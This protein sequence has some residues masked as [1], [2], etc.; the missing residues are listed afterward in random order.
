M[1]MAKVYILLKLGVKDNQGATVC[2]TLKSIGF[3]NIAEVRVGKYIELDLTS[4]SKKEA[5]VEV[6]Q[7]CDKLLSNTVIERYSYR[8]VKK[9]KNSSI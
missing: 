1:L 3:Q 4:I 5:M 8:I 7:M 6:E 2:K 9:R